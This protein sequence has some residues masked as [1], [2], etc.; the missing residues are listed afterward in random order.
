MQS[1]LEKSASKQSRENRKLRT[2][3]PTAL[4]DNKKCFSCKKFF[5]K[6]DLIDQSQWRG[7]ENCNNWFC[8]NCQINLPQTEEAADFLCLKCS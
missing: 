3:N 5:S 8:S 2:K 4:N 1:K 7:C 6:D